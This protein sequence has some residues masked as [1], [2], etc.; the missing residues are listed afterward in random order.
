MQRE[1]QSAPEGERVVGEKPGN[2]K[3]NEGGVGGVE[4]NVDQVIAAGMKAAESVVDRVREHDDGAIEAAVAFD[5]LPVVGAEDVARLAKPRMW[6]SG[7]C[8]T[9]EVSSKTK[10][11][12]RELR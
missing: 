2:E 3:K 8:S 7:L 1:Q 5:G 6:R 10:S 12:P 9:S 11:P 4:E